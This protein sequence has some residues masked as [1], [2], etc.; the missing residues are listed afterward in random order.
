[1]EKEKLAKEKKSKLEEF[2]LFDID[3]INAT[4]NRENQRLL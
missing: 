4:P 2:M 3:K 1:M